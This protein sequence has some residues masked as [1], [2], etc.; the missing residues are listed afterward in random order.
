M[1]ATRVVAR[2]A[3]VLLL[4]AGLGVIGGFA[5]LRGAHG[6]RWLL[7]K[8]V[9][10]AQP[11]SGSLAIDALDTDL[12]ST[13]SLRGVAIRD[14]SGRVVLSV[15]TVDVDF[16]LAGLL[17]R[18]VAVTRLEASGVQGALT[19]G[20]GGV[21]V[22]QLWVDPAAPAKPAKP[23][24]G[25]PV[26][27]SIAGIDVG[28]PHLGFVSGSQ[29]IVLTD[30]TVRGGV[31]FDGDRIGV[32]GL[33]IDAS[34]TP[35]LGALG[36]RAE[37]SYD[38]R[39]FVVDVL[40]VTLG[41][42]HLALSGTLGVADAGDQA[43]GVRIDVAHLDTNGVPWD[44]PIHGAFDL[45]GGVS[46]LLD[47]PV[48]ALQ[49]TT[50]GGRVDVDATLDQRPA[51]PTW[52]AD[53]R[54]YALD[55]DTFVVGLDPTTV[56]LS[57]SANGAGL[58]WP[59][60]LDADVRID[61]VASVAHRVG[62]AEVHGSVALAR[63][64][65]VITDLAA[66]TPSG[67]VAASA[68]VDLVDE[69]ATVTAASLDA[70]LADLQRF[71]LAGLRGSAGFAGE[72]AADWS[73]PAVAASVAGALS[74]VGVGYQGTARVSRF[75]GPIAVDWADGGG[76][77]SAD[78]AL[79][80]VDAATARVR[81]SRVTARGTATEHGELQVNATLG[82]QEL[83]VGSSTLARLDGAAHVR[84]TRAGDLASDLVFTTTRL[85]SGKLVADRA[86][87]AVTVL[88]DTLVA[89]LDLFT[90]DRTLLGIDASGDVRTRQFEVQRLIFSPDAN[91]AWVGQGVQT[92]A[93]ADDGVESMRIDIAAE[94]TPG[95]AGPPPV[96]VI[97]ASGGL[98]TRGDVGLK[99]E[100]V[101]FPLA[102][103]EFASPQLAGYSGVVGVDAALDGQWSQADLTLDATATGVTIPGA[104]RDLAADVH[105]KTQGGAFVVDA[106]VSEAAKPLLTVQGTLPVS[107]DMRDPGLRAAEPVD[108]TLEVLAGDS[109]RWNAVIDAADLPELRGSG[110]VVLTGTPLQPDLRVVALVE[111]PPADK[112]D[113]WVGLTLDASSA[114]SELTLA[115]TL[116]EGGEQRAELT[117]RSTSHL[118]RIAGALLDG[119]AS[120]DLA[121]PAT[122][123]DDLDFTLTPD[124]PM[125]TLRALVA[126]PS[127]VEGRLGGTV[128]LRG[129]PNAPLLDA[130]LTVDD[131]RLDT[132]AVAPATLAFRPEAAGYALDLDLG[133]GAQ[134]SVHATAFLPLQLLPG[135]PLGPQLD[136][137]GLRVALSG[138]GIPLAA[139]AALWP[140]MQEAAGQVVLG[141]TVTGSVHAPVGSLTLSAADASFRLQSTDVAY[142]QVRFDL[143][144][145]P[146]AVRLDHLH[147]RTSTP[148]ENPDKGIQGTIDGSVRAQII[149][150]EL[151]QWN[152]QLSLHRPLISGGDRMLRLSTG[153]IAFAGTPP[154]VHVTGALQVEEA[155]IHLDERFFRGPVGTTMPAWLHVHRSHSSAQAEAP[156][157]PPAGIPSWL[158]LKMGL[159]LGGNTFLRAQL[160]L[161]GSL[162]SLLGP[163]A[164]ISVDTQADGQLDLEVDDGAL[165]ITG[166]V[167]PVRGTTV[168]FGKAFQV[169]DDSTISFTGRDYASPVLALHATYD[170]R[171]YGV[172]TANITGVPEA[173]R[174]ALSSTEYPSQDDVVSLLLVGKP[175][176]E[177]S[178]GEG[179]SEGAA[180]AALSMLLTTVGQTLG[181]EGERTAAMVIAPDLLVV[182]N[183]TARVGKRIGKRLFVEVDLDQTADDQTASYLVLTL[184]YALGGPWG[185]E[186]THGTAG[187]DALE[188]TWT[189]RY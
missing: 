126:V 31:T 103:L 90:P 70:D 71:G 32:T 127:Q 24:T 9:Q 54:A 112:G 23:W 116:Q 25:L 84:R 122:W 158:Q 55:V 44:L 43:V 7:A 29:A 3:L 34:S 169:E 75:D 1:S 145:D 13:L 77:F 19:L 101:D 88:G 171:T 62:A 134:G 4:G 147:L 38:P 139:V 33:A 64:V 6:Q 186:F 65:A 131:A 136:R 185:A 161:S 53:V 67:A 76:A 120:P 159:D 26:T 12:H 93:L 79:R 81:R 114:R 152:G 89:K 189:R 148:G 165:S 128:R 108:L 100:V 36:V 133:F 47:A 129:S 146:D 163:F 149:G 18:K 160:P 98:H 41:P 153:Q 78:L 8:V 105:A 11:H 168:I 166:Q 40:D 63:G 86:E 182:G 51:R 5:W 150:N 37:L 21:D 121:D 52:S 68:V 132:V 170:T 181:R 94:G 48:L 107:L 80:G 183:Q 99:V 27:L 184:E 16:T 113:D 154:N 35:D 123:V 162:G 143:A 124:L 188:L 174:V 180:S 66:S 178:S 58:E 157:A 14:A 142:D 177:M 137:E 138:D 83:S 82:A 102:L 106:S 61:G 20:E 109:K 130:A 22:A 91:Q 17:K 73:G 110:K 2:G 60:D 15:A 176:S 175:A 49:A 69:H 42:Q 140:E 155:K 10:V 179:A 173:L 39:T 104:V 156:A 151:G 50:P 95:A 125:Q 96:A 115:A 187:E 172:V 119:G 56:D 164:S 92:V 46:G 28:V 85:E 59:E 135:E 30:A 74:G 97:R 45:R 111:A 117:G 141:G 72:V 144:L 167:L 57:V 118:Q 87:G